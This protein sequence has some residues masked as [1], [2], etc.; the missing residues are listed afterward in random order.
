VDNGLGSPLCRDGAAAELSQTSA[1]N[2]RI[3]GFE[4]AQAPTGDF[5]FDVHVNAGVADLGNYLV[6][7][8]QDVLEWGWTVLVAVVHGVI[9]MLEWCYTID[10]LDSS[11][12]SGVT[13]A[14]RETQATF[15]QPWLVL[16]L[17]GASVLALYHGIVRR[18]VTETLGQALL[19]AVMML[20]GLWV[21]V[22]PTGTVGALGGWANQASLGTLGAVAG[23]T[24][25][26]PDRT[27]A[28]SMQSVFSGAIGGP[29]CY[30][31]FG[32]VRW[33]SDPARLDPRL[34]TV[35]LLIAARER[36]AIGEQSAELLRGARTNGELFLALPANAAARNAI[37]PYGL[38][39]PIGG[40]FNVLCG[41]SQ[42]PCRGPT[43]E[44]ATFRT[45][46]GTFWRIAG[47][48]LIWVGVL[49]MVL[50]LG[51]IA[52]R[53]LGA[54][55]VGL[56]LLMLAPAAVIAP[57][58]GDGGR[59][60]FR[61]WAARLLGAVCSKLI[62][63][64][65]LGV[66]LLLQRT[67]MSLDAFGWWAQWLLVSTMWWGAFLQRQQ[68][69]G[70][71]HG[72]HRVL[73]LHLQQRSLM[74]RARA[75]LER[76]PEVARGAQW[77][78]RKLRKPPPSMEQ[79]RKLAR[80]GGEWAKGAAD[81][82][83]RR[84]LE[85]EQGEARALAQAA[86]ETQ[87]R[88]SAKRAQLG[89][90]EGAREQALAGG[91][92]RRAAKLGARAQRIEG[93]VAHEQQ[94]LNAARQTA[95]DDEKARRGPGHAHTREQGEQQGR[96]LDAQAALPAGRA[97]RRGHGGEASDAGSAPGSGGADRSQS[98]RRDYAG[99]AGLAGYGS[100]EYEG[101]DA[102]KQRAARL[103]IDR[104][105]A[106]RKE[107]NATAR[108]VAAGGNGSLGRREKRKMDRKSDRTLEQRLRADGHE[109][110]ASA[111][112]KP[113]ALDSYLRDGRTD[114]RPA[115]AR[116]GESSVM[117]DAREV[118]ARRKRQLGRERRR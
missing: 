115:A 76:P 40:L 30:L 78:K 3:S 110:P 112:P 2:C 1:R 107:L 36:A 102:R 80:A 59:A 77:V 15:T 25:D 14:L 109:L 85:R 21:I 84:T 39:R 8:V 97:R 56:F 96:F 42:E 74:Q 51:F 118:A 90:V 111:K 35:G 82:Q 20:G 53:L 65:L 91:D 43:A 60:A 108:D 17:A 22:N 87:A 64:F 63:S 34:H 69:L 105:L 38:L 95:A 103:E 66:V 61:G 11:A 12:M 47:L 79:R 106:L 67:L 72:E 117:R 93:E 31:E 75:K 94:T 13:R 27:L 49:G 86:P 28:E 37:N 99:M 62:Y 52:L 32:N 98:G 58:L 23:G 88:I 101:L 7:A 89:R 46:S 45:Q 73:R 54:A 24:P 92:T 48:F 41:G 9:V 19:M 18:Q 33:C 26:H 113:S 114:R 71:A 6:V 68:V 100:K 16:A 50:L 116:R 70:F 55:I 29:W 81:E 44:Q 4:A 83:V 104:E 10:L 5:A 57:A